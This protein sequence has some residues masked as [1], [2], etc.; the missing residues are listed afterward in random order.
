MPER[1]VELLDTK[2]DFD[3]FSAANLPRLVVAWIDSSLEEE[4]M[5]LNQM[6]SLRDLMSARNK[7]ATSQEVPKS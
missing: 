7:A 6:R 2:A 4:E 3:R 5:A 1:P